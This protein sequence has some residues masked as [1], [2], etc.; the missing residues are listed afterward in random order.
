MSNTNEIVRPNDLCKIFKISRTTLWR[1]A[2]DKDFP[3]AIH[4]TPRTVGF[5][6]SEIDE[7][8]LNQRNSA[9]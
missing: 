3:K 1:W 4:L 9:A 8:I 6:R 7:W 5:V 2:K